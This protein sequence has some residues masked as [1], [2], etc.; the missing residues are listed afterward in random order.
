MR[1]S[2]TTVHDPFHLKIT[3]AG[4]ASAVRFQWIFTE[5]VNL[6]SGLDRPAILL[7]ERE[8]SFH[9]IDKWD[10]MTALDFLQEKNDALAGTR[11]AILANPGHDLGVAAKFRDLT[12]NSVL[13]SV[14]VF[15]V[16]NEAIQWL[17]GSEGGWLM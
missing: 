16:E 12:K 8:S 4:E 15:S 13:A 3:T 2:I 7:D 10:L 14:E 9:M 1:Y 6:V 5:V 11:I 17:R